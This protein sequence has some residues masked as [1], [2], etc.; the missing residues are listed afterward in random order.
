MF[1]FHSEADFFLDITDAPIFF[2]SWLPL[3]LQE[4]LRRAFLL[5]SRHFRHRL[6]TAFAAADSYA[7]SWPAAAG[8]AFADFAT[9]SLLLRHFLLADCHFPPFS[10]SPQAV[11]SIR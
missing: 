3:T 8:F 10:A 11:T 1:H 6:I 9:F 4:Q 7:F 5:F 2:A